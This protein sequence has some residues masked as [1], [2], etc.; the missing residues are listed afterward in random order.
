MKHFFYHF[1]TFTIIFISLST[2]LFSQSLTPQILGA[3]GSY[4]NDK[5]SLC[6]TF[7]EPIISTISHDTIY[8]TQG[9]QQ[10]IT[11]ENVS[12]SENKTITIKAAIYPNPVKEN[13]HIKLNNNSLDQGIITLY[14]SKGILL[15]RKKLT[16]N[17]TKLSLRNYPPD[18][19]ILHLRINNQKQIFRIVKQK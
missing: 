16:Q 10:N 3:G 1:S 4:Y 19:Y 5:I 12:S 7:G 8:L 9:F 6:W 11:L 17:P 2:V 14:N 13:L 18:I 15:K